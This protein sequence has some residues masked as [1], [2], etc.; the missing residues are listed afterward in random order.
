[1]RDLDPK[2][3]ARKAIDNYLDTY[4]ANCETYKKSL[5]KVDD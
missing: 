2:G 3:D 1:M 5:R 4:V